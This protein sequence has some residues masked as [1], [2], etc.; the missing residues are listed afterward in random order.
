M[1]LRGANR[2]LLI[3]ALIAGTASVAVRARSRILPQ[4]RNE[5][6]QLLRHDS[7]IPGREVI[8]FR[9]GLDSGAMTPRHKHPGDEI[10]LV[11]GGAV[12]YRLDGAPPLIVRE[13]ESF[14]IPA[15]VVHAVTNVG[16][17][18]ATEL[19]TYVAE[20]GTPLF[21]FMN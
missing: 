18:Y 20:K 4:P 7:S 1:G 3:G 15:G 17:G 5:F 10:V 16:T 11:L 13:G 21:V 19:T 14:F 6:V 2:T 9:V 12:E 8:Q